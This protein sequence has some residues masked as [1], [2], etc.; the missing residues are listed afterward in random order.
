MQAQKYEGRGFLQHDK[1]LYQPSKV[2]FVKTK[3]SVI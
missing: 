3:G 2:K 1:I